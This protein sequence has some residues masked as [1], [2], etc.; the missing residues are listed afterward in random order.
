MLRN[1]RDS[2][3]SVNDL[4]LSY[5]ITGVCRYPVRIDVGQVAPVLHVVG[6]SECCDCE[7]DE[8]EGEED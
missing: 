2:D 5:E 1:G 6:E 8:T 3:S 7:R 4:R